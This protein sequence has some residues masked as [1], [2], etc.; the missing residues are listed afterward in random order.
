LSQDPAA[1][2]ELFAELTG[3]ITSLKEKGQECIARAQKLMEEEE[4]AAT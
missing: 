4:K 2:K 1:P 3:T